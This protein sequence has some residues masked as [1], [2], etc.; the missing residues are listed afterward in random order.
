[1]IGKEIPIGKRK[2]GHLYDTAEFCRRG[3]SVFGK[4]QN[5]ECHRNSDPCP[6]FIAGA[7]GIGLGSEGEDLRRCDHPDSRNDLFR[8]RRTGR[9]PFLICVPFLLL[10]EK[11]A[12]AYGAGRAG[13]A[14]PEPEAQEDGE[15]E[16]KERIRKGRCWA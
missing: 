7:S 13:Q 9:E 15:E 11:E 8:L 12:A 6:F 1:M 16:E 4:G 10:S 2:S 5:Q 3:N 14:E